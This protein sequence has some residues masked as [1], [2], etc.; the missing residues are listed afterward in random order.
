MIGII[1]STLFLPILWGSGGSYGTIPPPPVVEQARGAALPLEFVY[2]DD[3]AALDAAWYYDWD[4]QQP[5]ET[6]AEFVPILWNV[7]QAAHMGELPEGEWLLTMNEPNYRGQ[8]VASPQE[9]AAIWPTLEA[10]R[11]KLV[12]PAVSACESASDPNCLNQNWL[13]EWMALC[14]DCRYEAIALHWYG[15]DVDQLTAYL[16]RRHAQF[17][18]KDIWLTEFACSPWWE[19]YGYAAPEEFM[20]QALEAIRQRPW[21]TRYAWF[22]S[23]TYLCPWFEPL[24]SYDGL[25]GLGQIYSED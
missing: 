17:P 7:A 20:A 24:V 11:R 8:G 22:A 5:C 4:W 19:P 3:V 1:T 6:D 15:C 23:R 9:V 25:T 21:I 16:D 18:G 13:E 10:T 2:C 12:S 14:Q